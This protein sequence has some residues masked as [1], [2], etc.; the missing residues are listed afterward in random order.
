MLRKLGG[1]GMG[2]VYEAE[3]L[4]LDRH[5]ALKFLPPGVAADATALRR[6]DREARASSALNH[7]NICTIYDIDAAE[8]QPFIAMEL[9]DGKTLKHT[10]EGK[11]LD[12][13]LLLD[14]AI[15]IADA[16][17]AAHSAGIIHRDIKPANIFV[18][19]RGQAKVL[20]FGLA[21]VIAC[22]PTATDDTAGTT[23]LTAPGGAVGTLAYMSPEQIR[24]KELDTRSDLFSFG[25][26]LYE[27]ATGTPPFRGESLHVLADSILRST[28]TPPVR[29][30]PDL[31]V[32]L[33]EIIS[34]ALEKDRE[35]RYQHAAD[36]RSDLKRLKRKTESGQTEASSAAPAAK[37][38]HRG[39]R[40]WKFVI[41]L[42]IAAIAIAA[43]AFFYSHRAPALSDKDTIVLAD[44]DNKTGDPVFD[45]TL[46]QALAV[47]LEQSPF[48]NVLPDEKVNATLRLMNRSPNDRLTENVARDLCQRA[49]SKAMLAGSIDGL[50]SHYVIGLKALNCT[51][52]DSL[53]RE[54][55]QAAAKEEVLKA[56]STAARN[57]RG[58]LGE[59]LSTIQKFDTPVEQ[60]TTPSLDALKAYSLGLKTWN[61][62]GETA[63]VPLF[64]RAVELDPQFAIAYARLGSA[65]R[66]LDEPGLAAEN[67]RKAFSL[68]QKVSERERLYIEVRYYRYVTGEFEKWAQVCELWKLTYPRDRVPHNDLAHAYSAFGQYNK[69][70][71]EASEALRLEPNTGANYSNL[72]LYYLS[73]NRLNEAESALNK[74]Q[75]RKLESR[76]LLWSRYQLAFVQR[77]EG[78]MKRLVE[79]AV[80]KPGIEDLL[81][82]LQA[83]TETYNG[84]LARAR[85]LRRRAVDL[86][87]DNDARE[88]AAGYLAEASLEEAYFGEA[89]Q[90]RA[91][92]DEALRL[93]SNRTVQGYAALALALV[94]DTTG[95]EKLADELNQTLPLDTR[96]QRHWLPTIRAVLALQGKN[97]NQAIEALQV[98]T[99]YELGPFGGSNGCLCPAYA[100]GQANLML[101]NGSAAAVEFQKIIDHRGI[102]T[103]FPL[104]AL[105]HVGLGRA[106]ALQ[107]DT[108]KARA[109]YQDFLTLWKNADPDIPILQQA[110]TEYAKL[111]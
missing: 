107:G 15:Q 79:Q 83:D 39:G 66:N 41:P 106:Y 88:A 13:E 18:T 35:L 102:V 26:V 69:S 81:L 20:D 74:A 65:Y 64:K 8:G 54:Q 105:A 42:G 93:A 61:M 9:L 23:N 51:S 91:D 55:V 58:K 27:M 24:A 37:A 110:K 78:E 19:K 104:G 80:G 45:D 76:D 95:A 21:K 31:P 98:A 36:M 90:A 75:E 5:V 22:Q 70:V 60:A 57:V 40:T 111:Q 7:P 28:P 73:L 44:F 12:M 68:R 109:A 48:L 62:K 84:R 10:I 92:A 1:G 11:P 4:K 33:E 32:K 59:A 49:G 2:V 3:D 14:L 99:P 17:D 50:G 87:K 100:R 89:K 25:M 38:E 46:K 30:N 67:V 86:A 72:A 34:K 16:L 47:Q 94:G 96:V 77:D 56:L 52:G 85:E 97:P 101:R 29:L 103:N 63:A 82:G 71:E 43:G 6:F 53:A 108:A